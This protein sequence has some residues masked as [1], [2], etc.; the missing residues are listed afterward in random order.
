MA[1]GL[2]FRIYIVEGLYYYYVAETKALISC[3]ADLRLCFVYAKS[4]FSHAII[5]SIRISFFQIRY[6]LLHGTCILSIVLL[7]LFYL[8]R[9]VGSRN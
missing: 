1:R 2:K 9:E 7:F 8:N 6:K 4:T 5:L 3:A